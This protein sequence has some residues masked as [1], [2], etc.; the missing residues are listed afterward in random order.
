MLV[1]IA[2]GSAVVN[3]ALPAVTQ[4]D[5]FSGG[6]G[7][8]SDI[9]TSY[10]SAW[11]LYSIGSSWPMG[12]SGGQFT[13][14]PDGTRTQ[15]GNVASTCGSKGYD[16]VWVYE[17]YGGTA[18]DPKHKPKPTS[19]TV[20][21]GKGTNYL[22]GHYNDS[23]SHTPQIYSNSNGENVIK[24]GTDPGTVQSYYDALPAAQRS[25]FTWGYNVASFCYQNAPKDYTL[26]PTIIANQSTA[27]GGSPIN[28]TPSVANAGHKA[29]SNT[30]WQISTFEI[31]SGSAIPV[32]ANNA[33][34]PCTYYDPAHKTPTAPP[35]LGCAVEAGNTGVG[36][37]AVGAS[38]VYT[39]ASGSPFGLKSLTV[40]D[41]LAGTKVCYAL[42]VKARAVNTSGVTDTN[43]AQSAPFCITIGKLPFV[44]I[45]G[46]DLIGQG[47]VTTS[48]T[49]KG[50]KTFGSWIEYGIFALKNIVGAGS[51]S[52]YSGQG[53][54]NATICN[55]SLLSFTNAADSTGCKINGMIGNYTNAASMPNIAASFPVVTSGANLTPTLGSNDLSDPTKSGLFTAS[56][57]LTLNAATIGAGRW[58]VLNA[59]STNVTITGNITYAD[60]PYTSIT[61][62]PQLI[63]IAGNITIAD[64]VTQVDAWLIAS[65]GTIA[66][67]AFTSK[68]SGYASFPAFPPFP[69]ISSV[70]SP[71][72]KKLD[73]TINTC[74]QQL[75]VNG[76]VMAQSLDLLRTAGSNPGAASGDPAEV[77]NL[78]PDAYLWTMTHTVA[79]GRLQTTYTTELPPRL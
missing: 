28:V 6:G 20:K 21:S 60:G 33:T 57:N 2:V 49:V 16:S 32:A 39:G 23:G 58:V 70:V 44:Q 63:I 52:A 64:S 55:E 72:T 18:G 53:L 40:G 75:T 19:P 36:G 61:Q 15:W 37:F 69:S 25:G 41:Y 67:C 31:A 27:E 54:A 9:C 59:P 73:L 42:S 48:T 46:N 79:G 35:G 62:I 76:P 29:S 14:N 26:I 13:R 4:A 71:P 24:S 43:W 12:G 78:R 66:T 56:G 30:T 34:D 3:V 10:M 45:L 38:S 68:D 7:S 77:F 17:V 74:N 22:P 11:N 8:C 50:G 65:N 47:N 51:G 5:V 1:A